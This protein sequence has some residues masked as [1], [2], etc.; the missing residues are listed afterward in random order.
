MTA[1]SGYETLEAMAQ[2]Q[3]SADAAPR[4]VVISFGGRSLVIVE[5]DDRAIAHWPLAT[6]QAASDPDVTPLMLIPDGA[7]EENLLLDDPTMIEAIKAVCPSFAPK[8][9]ERRPLPIGSILRVV[10]VLGLL[11]GGW[12]GID[13]L[14]TRLVDMVPVSQQIA[15]A[16]LTVDR[17][18]TLPLQD[19]GETV[20]I[21]TD[22]AGRAALGAIV[23]RLGLDGRATWPEMRVTVIDTGGG[24]GLALLASDILIARGAVETARRPEDVAALIAHLAAHAARRDPLV[25]VTEALGHWRTAA[26]VIGMPV[27]DEVIG[28]AADALVA[29]LPPRDAED[30]AARAGA[31]MMALA[32]LPDGVSLPGTGAP[33][34]V[35]AL[36]YRHQVAPPGDPA[37]ETIAFDPALT[38]Q[39]WLAL[40]NICEERARLSANALNRLAPRPPIVE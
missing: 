19:A 24:G 17:L 26:L 40:R 30:A 37:I 21:C 25:A 13:V 20:S 8:V 35:P 1:A 9:E 28:I 7:A 36:A 2:Y 32:D 15:L 4:S 18:G 27:E 11:A 33:A 22:P 5:M 31:E 10:L 39:D 6:L 34:A 12:Y 29:G 14:R 16:D 3:E 38:D 23:A